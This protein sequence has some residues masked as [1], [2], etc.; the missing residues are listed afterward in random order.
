MFHDLKKD[1]ARKDARIAELEHDVAEWSTV[2][3]LGNDRIAAA[4]A[5]GVIFA[6][7]GTTCVN[8]RAEDAEAKVRGL[9]A[10]FMCQAELEG[11]KR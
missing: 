2:A 8:Q 6:D 10:R 9:S 1:N 5:V 3:N 4:K 7:P 11:G